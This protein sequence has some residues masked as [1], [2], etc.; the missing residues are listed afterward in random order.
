[1]KK[2]CINVTTFKSVRILSIG[3][4]VPETV[5]TNKD[6]EKF[7]DTS[8]E[9]IVTRTGIRER[10]I[11]PKDTAVTNAEL[12]AN[13]AK[14]ALK[15]AGVSPDQV[16][17]IIC[18]TTT[19]DH[20]F[21]STACEIQA[22]IGCKNAFAFDCHAACAGFVYGLSIAHNFVRGGQGKTYLVIGAEIMSRSMDWTDRATCILFGD[23]AG[24]AVIQG[25]GE[26]NT[27]IL[28]TYLAA[29]GT[30]GDILALPVWTEKRKLTM[31]GNEVFKHAVRM[32]S[33]ISIKALAM[34]GLS[35]ENIDYFIPHQANIRIINAIGEFLKLPKEKI[36]INLERFGN[37]SSASIPLVLNDAWNEGKLK[38]GTLVLFTA[39]G[40][41]L[42]S[43]SA[44][45]KF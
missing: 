17:G 38:P 20:F 5:M 15:R 44:V 33:D 26:E 2:G 27:G 42:A 40:G 1:M 45:V 9:W 12:G 37:T 32:M 23:G 21:P 10:R 7:L 39:L 19:P 4:S 3:T 28:S 6:F 16:D 41:G 29:D 11:L 25:S 34:A 24:A 8:D 30:L 18:A 14:E 35:L 43:G 31:K 13:A 22:R 36:L